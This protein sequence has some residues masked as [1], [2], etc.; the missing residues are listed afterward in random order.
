MQT[1]AIYAMLHQAP[2]DAT[3]VVGGWW[4]FALDGGLGIGALALA[5]VAAAIGYE[6]MFLLLPAILML[7]LSLRAIE[8]KLGTGAPPNPA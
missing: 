3:A 1:G 5:P 2:R 4:N 7:A 6:S 8:G